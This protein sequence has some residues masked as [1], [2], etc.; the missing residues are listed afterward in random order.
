MNISTNWTSAA[1]TMINDTYSKNGTLN[2]IRMYLF[3]SQVIAEESVRTNVTAKPI[4]VADSIFPETPRK[5]HI[6]RK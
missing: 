1:M 4:L 5:G 6:P 3:M 2:A